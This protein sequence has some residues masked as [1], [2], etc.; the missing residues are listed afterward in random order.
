MTL[1][2]FLPIP[3]PQTPILIPP[4]FANTWH[5]PVSLATDKVRSGW[6]AFDLGLVHWV[7]DNPGWTWAI[8]T[9][10]EGEAQIEDEVFGFPNFKW[11]SSKKMLWV[12][13]CV[14]IF[15]LCIPYN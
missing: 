7:K 11:K 1:E 4:H 12:V 15:L 3:A 10:R 14:Y 9:K 8:E 5:Q 6:P 13:M 2:A